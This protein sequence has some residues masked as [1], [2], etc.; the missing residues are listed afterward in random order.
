MSTRKFILADLSRLRI[1]VVLLE[2]FLFGFFRKNQSL[3]YRDF[4]GAVKKVVLT[5]VIMD[6]K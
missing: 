3:Q 5:N 4:D 1:F 2:N 6:V